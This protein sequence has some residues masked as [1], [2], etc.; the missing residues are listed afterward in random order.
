MSE[1]ILSKMK[2]Y[3]MGYMGS[4]KSTLGKRAA[5]KMKW[6]FVDTDKLIEQRYGMEVAEIFRLFGES[7]FRGA[8]KEILLE[9]IDKENVIIATGGGMP[10]FF[11]NMEVMNRTGKTIYIHLSPDELTARLMQTNL[12]KRPLLTQLKENDLEK[13]ITE[14]LVKREPFYL[15]AQH[16]IS[17]T[18]DEMEEK[19]ILL[20]K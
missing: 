1:R 17:G 14:N 18:D 11:D 12:A 15:Q 8:E 10:C 19:I 4:G 2:A 20:L 5:E 16:H 9:L 7:E 3:L 6:E 13:F